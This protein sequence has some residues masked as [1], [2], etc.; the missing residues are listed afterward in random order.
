MR[1]HPAC[2]TSHCSDRW[3]LVK[4]RMGLKWKPRPDC[5][6]STACQLWEHGQAI[7]PSLFVRCVFLQY[8]LSIVAVKVH[9]VNTYQNLKQWLTHSK[10]YRDCYCYYYLFWI[11][12]NND[13]N[14]SH[15]NNTDIEIKTHSNLWDEEHIAQEEMENW[16]KLKAEFTYL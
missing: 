5:P 11:W 10:F 8:R 2:V 3:V 15:F 6:D 1:H 14:L 4:N 16:Y 7:Q 9:W 13:L 12:Q